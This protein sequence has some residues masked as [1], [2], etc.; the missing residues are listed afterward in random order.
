MASLD[1][2]LGYE[3]I[4]LPLK[5]FTQTAGV[6]STSSVEHLYDYKD[7]GTVIESDIFP[8]NFTID[9]RYIDGVLAAKMVK[10]ARLCFE[11]PQNIPVL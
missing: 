11:N 8:V 3:D 4:Y 2:K 10:H 7:D 6:F 9:H 5:P 1:S